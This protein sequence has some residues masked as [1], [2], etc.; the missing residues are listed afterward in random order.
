MALKRF[1]NDDEATGLTEEEMVLATRW[2]RHYKTRG[3]VHGPDQLRIYE[4]FMTGCS[5][6][7]I[8]LAFPHLPHGQIILTV[9]LKK[10]M[11]DREQIMHSLKERVQAKIIKHVMEQVDFLTSMLSVA[12]AEHMESYKAYMRDPKNVPKPDLR[13]NSIKDY[14]EVTEILQKLVSG[15][16]E[17][18]NKGDMAAAL[19]S[20]PLTGNK[21]PL[22]GD[23]FSGGKKSNSKMRIRP[24]KK[25]KPEIDPAKLIESVMDS[26]T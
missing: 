10:W 16:I 11:L 21:G 8:H 2:L 12:N 23:R 24:A 25:K 13:V 3:I 7:E 1:L 6:H 15:I 14:K 26:D 4:M 20:F 22:P 18:K 5:F 9:A 17:P 19:D